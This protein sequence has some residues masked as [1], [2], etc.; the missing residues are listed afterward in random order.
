M[1][2]NMVGFANYINTE[3][4]NTNNYSQINPQDPIELLN[5]QPK[6][7]GILKRNHIRC[8]S[9]LRNTSEQDLKNI[10]SLGFKSITY[11][12]KIKDILNDLLPG[13]ESTD[14]KVEESQRVEKSIIQGLYCNLTPVASLLDEFLE[15]LDE[16]NK[17]ILMER[18]GLLNGDRKTL[19]EIGSQYG[20]TRERIRQI[21]NKSLL[22][23]KRGMRRYSSQRLV[24]I[25]GFLLGNNSHVVS[26]EEADLLVNKFFKNSVYDGSSI[27]D[28]FEELKIISKTDIGGITLYSNSKKCNLNLLS[29]EV[30]RIIRLEKKTLSV[31]TLEQALN[32]HNWF[33]FSH[34]EFSD[35][36]NKYAYLDP[37]IT[38]FENGVVTTES[39]H[40]KSLWMILIKKVLVEASLP[41]HYTEIADK[42]NT[43]IEDSTLYVDPRRVHSILIDEKEFAH[44]GRWGM[45]GL[46]SWGFRKEGTPELIKEY[47]KKAG[48]PVHL[49]QIF[50]Y[51]GKY[52]DTSRSNIKSVLELNKS[53]VKVAPNIYHLTKDF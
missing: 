14:I 39:S 36:F 1:N 8:V 23:L 20:L 37:R 33:Q 43:Y 30:F 31:D 16:R 6:I 7:Q 47:I 13:N 44:T 35:F 34:V 21:Q 3:E 48:Y 18:F 46:S 53:F 45:Y 12:N 24:N 27:L 52:K 25:I 19:E 51:V 29:E 26:G 42:I 28:L 17:L 15:V 11:L 10:F 40:K 22:K 9:D 32:K 5:L 38:L 2:N 41:L 4:I 50:A 49:D